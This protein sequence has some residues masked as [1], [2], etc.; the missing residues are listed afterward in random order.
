MKKPQ[1]YLLLILTFCQFSNPCQLTASQVISDGSDGAFNPVYNETIDL[2]TAAPD[3][4]FNFTTIH[5]PAGVT[6]RF[7]GNTTNTP[8]FFAATGSIVIEGII[9]VSGR[10]Y[11]GPAGPGGGAGGAGGIADSAGSDGL[12]PAGGRGGPQATVDLFH[13][14]AGGGGGMATPGLIA[15]NRTGKNP[16]LPGGAVGRTALSS[17]VSGGG[18]SGGGGG[19]GMVFFAVPINGGLGGGG[20]GG[21]QLSTPGNLTISG[22]IIA[23]GGHGSTAYANGLNR[24][25]GPG[26]GGSGGGN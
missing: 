15:T 18:G 10:D 22:Q 8:V 19:C 3:G 23:N 9:D 20:G 16:G 6:I 21:L 24:F 26:G 7:T 12:G 5:I 17:G 25:T 4:V 14:N 1:N 11:F 13:G 2:N